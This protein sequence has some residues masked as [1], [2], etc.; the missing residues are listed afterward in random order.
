M[1]A[2]MFEFEG[3]TEEIEAAV[4][5]GRDEILALER[6]MPGFRGLIVLSDK[7]AGKLISLSLWETEEQMRRSEESARTITRLAQQSLGGKRRSIELF[8][9]EIFELVS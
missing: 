7:D 9:V 8:D 6:Q 4:A 1:H 2:R 3:G 5:L